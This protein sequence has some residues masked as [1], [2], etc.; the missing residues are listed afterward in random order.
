MERGVT[1]DG[2]QA[3]EK[4]DLAAETDT[5]GGNAFAA[6]GHVKRVV[7]AF[8]KTGD[9]GDTALGVSQ[10]LGPGVSGEQCDERDDEQ[11]AHGSHIDQCEIKAGEGSALP[12]L[13]VEDVRVLLPLNDDRHRSG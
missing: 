3:A 13:V 6:A 8:G 2:D 1:G 7:P 9:T 10:A 4:A 11:C 5:V 12:Y